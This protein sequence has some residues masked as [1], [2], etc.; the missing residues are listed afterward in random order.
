MVRLQWHPCPLFATGQEEEVQEGPAEKS[1][2]PKHGK[3]HPCKN[4]NS[5]AAGFFEVGGACQ[6]CA[7]TRLGFKVCACVRA[8][9]ETD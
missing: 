7:N 4:V 9:E 1:I 8:L 6:S 2:P 5:F 3:R